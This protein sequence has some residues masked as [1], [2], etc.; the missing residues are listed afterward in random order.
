MKSFTILMVA[1]TGVVAVLVTQVRASYITLSDQNNVAPSATTSASPQLQ[2]AEA[3]IDGKV[4]DGIPSEG[5]YDDTVHAIFSDAAVSSYTLDLTWSTAQHL[6]SLQAYVFYNSNDLYSVD[7]TV[8][9]IQF[10]VDQGA[11]FVS[12][13]TVNTTNTNTIG[14]FDLTKLDGD[15]SNVTK[16]RYQFTPTGT[17]GP[18][19]AE[20]LAIKSVPEPSTIISFSVGLL[21]LLAYAWRKR[22]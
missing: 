1:A 20:V 7:R 21:G 12:V 18:R 4:S 22:S 9:A 3:S 8:S 15:W 11:G 5:T 16:V 17:Q 14:A 6:A 10:F 2:R 19:V 13:G